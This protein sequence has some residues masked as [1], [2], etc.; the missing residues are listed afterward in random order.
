MEKKY[1]NLSILYTQIIFIL[2]S[3]VNIIILMIMLFVYFRII[4]LNICYQKTLYDEDTEK[5]VENY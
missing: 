3:V 1:A 4:N 2:I 5:N